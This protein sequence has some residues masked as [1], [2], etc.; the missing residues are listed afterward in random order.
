[1]RERVLQRTPVER[2]V[3][4]LVQRMLLQADQQISQ[5]EEEKREEEPVWYKYSCRQPVFL[6]RPQK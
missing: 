5:A 3:I 2:R 6:S 4:I 1:V